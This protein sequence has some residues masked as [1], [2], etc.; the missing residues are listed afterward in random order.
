[1]FRLCAY[2]ILF[3]GSV[4]EIWSYWNARS[5]AAV[6][7]ERQRIARD[8]HDGLAQ[9]L[10]YLARNLDSLQGELPEQRDQALGRLQCAVERAQRESR[11]AVSILAGP[12]PQPVEV[13]L[14]EA[15]AAVA[16]RFRLGLDLDVVFGASLSAAREDALVG[17]AREAVT[18][19]GRHSGA[20]R[21]SLKLEPDGPRMRLRIS[22]RGRG[23]D[24]T[25]TSGF[26][27]DLDA[28]TGTLG[29]R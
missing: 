26:G 23:F 12:C 14:A 7:A 3:V 13:A 5:E 17:I 1:M 27:V 28:R 15:T 10:A 21:V 8:L 4:R 25:V 6:L 24:T 16:E 29:R 2:G 22:D 20:A 9:E 18:N 19:A 11:R